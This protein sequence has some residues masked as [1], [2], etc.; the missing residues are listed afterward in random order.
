MNI[1]SLPPPDQCEITFVGEGAANVV[2]KVLIT[3]PPSTHDDEEVYRKFKGQRHP[4]P[5]HLTQ[6]TSPNTPTDHLLRVP[7]ANTTAYSYHDLQSYWQSTI[8][9]RFPPSNLVHQELLHWTSP[10]DV[11]PR[12]NSALDSI[13]DNRRPDFRGSRIALV[14]T[15]MLVADMNQSNPPSPHHC[16]PSP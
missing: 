10:D 9:P 16:L 8:V 3:T 14:T 11:I 2:F 7:K 6:K 13:D 12:L 1:T 4:H 5:T 15:G